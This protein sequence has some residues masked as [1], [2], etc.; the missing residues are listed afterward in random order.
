MQEE[1]KIY[2]IKYGQK[3]LEKI[4]FIFTK[5]IEIPISL[6]DDIEVKYK[7]KLY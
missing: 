2:R 4:I 7:I 1:I 5:Y 6:D 3:E